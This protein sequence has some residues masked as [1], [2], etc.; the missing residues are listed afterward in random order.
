[1][2]NILL[3]CFFLTAIFTT[4]VFGQE[5]NQ[6]SNK[7]K[8]IIV[9]GSVECHHCIET[10]A[11]LKEKKLPFV[12]YDID[13]N[14]EAL[15][16]MLTKLREAKISTSNLGIPVVDKKGVLFSNNGDFQEFSKKLE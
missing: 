14:P 7:S 11:Y 3:F 1:M 5:N 15:N 4:E 16:E 12:F 6:N 2:K 9:Y 8:S 13:K 10:K